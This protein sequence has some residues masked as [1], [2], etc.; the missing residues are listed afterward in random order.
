[1]TQR[2]PSTLRPSRMITTLALASLLAGAAP[3]EPMK[4]GNEGPSAVWTAIGSVGIVVGFVVA[5]F[6]V[7]TLGDDLD[8]A[9]ADAAG[10]PRYDEDAQEPPGRVYVRPTKR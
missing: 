8:D 9:L 2:S 4:R 10:V 1:M 6:V 3:H 5:L 7:D